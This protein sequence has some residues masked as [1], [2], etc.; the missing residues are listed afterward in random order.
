[1]GKG[2]RPDNRQRAPTQGTAFFRYPLGRPRRFLC[3]LVHGQAA[4][5]GYDVLGRCML[6]AGAVFGLSFP[7]TL[8]GGAVRGGVR[9]PLFKS[10]HPLGQEVTTFNALIE[11]TLPAC[12]C[13]V[14]AECS[15]LSVRGEWQVQ[16]F[17]RSLGLS[18]FMGSPREPI[19]VK[20]Q[21]HPRWSTRQPRLRLM[22]RLQDLR[23][24]STRPLAIYG[25]ASRPPLW[26]D[27]SNALAF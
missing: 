7:E 24:G 3:C 10:C 4:H 11:P 5:G 13:G 26:V 9:R 12:T 1:M 6:L 16:G 20:F 15:F 17:L 25:T 21:D 14:R 19:V 27:S 2:H 23:C 22:K 18:S 8:R